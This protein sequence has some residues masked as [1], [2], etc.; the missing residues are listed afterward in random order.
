MAS[1]SPLRLLH[2]ASTSSIRPSVASGVLA[3]SRLSS[4]YASSHNTDTLRTT[5]RD[6]SEPPPQS[7]E[8]DPPRWARPPPA[9]VAPVRTR[10]LPQNNIY[11]VN[12]DPQKLDEVYVK[13]LGSNGDR[14]LSEETKWLAVTH[15][16]FD[17]GRRGF[18]DRLTFLGGFCLVLKRIRDVDSSTINCFIE[19]V[20]K[21]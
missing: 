8:N 21:D 20:L 11:R 19:F 1:K 2:R 6:S 9:M 18:N 15:K 5:D 3:P 4:R 12:N 16:S 13:M 17:H 14:M 7:S 10:P